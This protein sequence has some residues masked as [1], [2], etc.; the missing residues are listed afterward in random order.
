MIAVFPQEA[1][2]YRRFGAQ[3]DYF[4]HPL[5][6]ALATPP[7]RQA[8]RTRLGLGAETP[9]ITLLP[10]SRWQE[11]K[12]VLPLMLTVAQRLQARSPELQFLIPLSMGKLRSAITHQVQRSGINARILEGDARTAIAAADLVLN[13]SGTV[14]LEVALINVPQIVIYRLNPITAR[15]AY[16]LLNFQVDYV[17]PVNLFM[18]QPIVPE[19][20]QWL[21]TVDDITATCIQMLEDADTRAAIL[22]GY[23]QLRQQMGQPGVCDRVAQELLQW[24]LA[25]KASA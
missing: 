24:A 22:A 2:Y 5:V 7:D 1:A 19:F 14:N 15:I 10:A 25:T 23:Q 17:S 9:V 16:Y 20:V 3:V 21:G 13:K 8:A 6:D 4:G 11:V 12:Y 18:N